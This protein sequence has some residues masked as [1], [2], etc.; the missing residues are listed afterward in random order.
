MGK[1]GDR[2]IERMRKV[3]R[4]RKEGEEGGSGVK[5][6]REERLRERGV[7]IKS[8]RNPSKRSFSDRGGCCPYPNTSQSVECRNSRGICLR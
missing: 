7:T 3:N 2:A 4:E 6:M 1:G 8:P 5:G